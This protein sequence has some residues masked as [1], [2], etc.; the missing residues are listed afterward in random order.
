MFPFVL[1]KLL[2]LCKYWRHSSIDIGTNEPNSETKLCTDLQKCTTC[3]ER[4]IMLR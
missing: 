1:Y 4:S 3:T 2:I